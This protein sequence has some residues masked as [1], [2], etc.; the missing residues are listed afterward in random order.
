MLIVLIHVVNEVDT[1]AVDEAVVVI[2][3]MVKV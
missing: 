2:K 1:A 3:H